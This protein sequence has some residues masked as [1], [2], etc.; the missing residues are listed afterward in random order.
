[1]Q[2]KLWGAPLKI[3]IFRRPIIRRAAHNDN[4]S[5]PAVIFIHGLDGSPAKTW[6]K[7][8]ATCLSDDAFSDFSIDCYA[9]P[10]RWSPPIFGRIANLQ[11]LSRG[12]DT[13]IRAHHSNRSELIIVA[14]SL[15]G[16][17]A[18]QYIVNTLKAQQ[19]LL[20]AKLMLIAVPHT[21][22][23]LAN[24]ATNI[25]GYH[26]QVTQLCKNADL[27]QIQ[28]DDWVHL[29]AEKMLQVRYV[30]GG[31]D[32]VVAPD[33][34]SP[35]MPT[36]RVHTLIGSNHRSIVE[37][38][39]KDDTRYIVLKQ[40]ALSGTT[41]AIESPVSPVKS[42]RPPD[43]LFDLYSR[44]DELFY[45]PRP[46]DNR[47]RAASL[48]GHIWV[49]GVSGVGKTT[50]ARRL[51][52]E[53]GCKLIQITLG[54]Y[55]GLSPVGLFRAICVELSEGLKAESLPNADATIADL[56][57]F[58]KRLLRDYG[59]AEALTILIEEIPLKGQTEF[60]EFLAQI[61][62]FM[63]ALEADSALHN[64]VRLVFTSIY[65]PSN[66]GGRSEK[67]HEKLQFLEM[68]LWATEHLRALS[69]VIARELNPD[70]SSTD[71]DLI[72]EAS[73]GSPRFVKTVFRHW[74]NGSHD[75]RSV[76]ELL[77]RLTV[78]RRHG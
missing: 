77:Q 58:A 41:P 46:I 78:D 12:L 24:V 56:L 61:L 69:R 16:L 26:P 4:G 13:E 72:A 2:N 49:T 39:N 34:A 60:E 53:S 31:A 21:G 63:L 1:M 9:Y 28:N 40:F 32:S 62:R 33:S 14:H 11:E 19:R 6:A 18:R 65:D 43:V 8:I 30:V 35:F 57:I 27:L 38:M 7:M 67:L 15:G 70:L 45:L 3:P 50:A 73:A 59:N 10:S 29:Q 64:A 54:G 71:L 22:A 48:A 42:G 25:Y 37:P 51:I 17:V 5:A 66:Y 68:Q 74:R 20:V 76:P 52:F 36:E 75:G 44:Q 47:L 55:H 23:T